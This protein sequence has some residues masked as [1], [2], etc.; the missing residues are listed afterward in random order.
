MTPGEL[1]RILGAP[2]ALLIGIGVAL[3]SGIFRAPGEV[4]ASLPS[5]GWIVIAWIAGGIVAL[6]QGMVTAELATRF[7]KAGGEYVYLREAYGDFVAFFFGWSYTVFIVGA[8]AASI[9]RALGDFSVELFQVGVTWAGPFAALAIIATTIVNAIGLRTG[10]ATQNTL[11]AL[12]V[13]A[14]LVVAGV[15]L[16]YT[17][18]ARDVGPAAAPGL[19]GLPSLS[20]SLTG[21]L[22]VF[23]S[24]AGTTDSVKLAEEI[25]DVRRALPRA[26]IGSAA[27]LTVVYLLFNVA[28]MRVVPAADMA[29]MPSVPGEAMER[30]L[31][32]SGRSAML[33]TAILICLGA[34]TSTVLTTVRVTFAL[35]RDGLAFG[36]LS[37]MS[38]AQSPVPALI[39]VAA[40]AIVLACSREFGRILGI[41]FLASTVLFG[42][43]YASLILFRMRE[44]S[45]PPNIFR[46]PLGIAQALVLIVFQ[47]A[48]AVNIAWTQPKDAQYTL[49]LLAFFAVLYLVWRKRADGAIHELRRGTGDRGA[50]T[51]AGRP[52]R[53]ADRTL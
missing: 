6:M 43:A 33:V 42:L 37:R 31:G 21:F 28:L 40:V 38:K 49:L 3:G 48:L 46:C 39:L 32:A 18:P 17:Q 35:A 45:V 19:T 10:A 29:G 8:G 36:V 50:R 4:A 27:A 23:W 34:L 41:Y 13:L 1:K 20:A 15:G 14:L 11:T 30:A 51:D 53:D 9:A 7:P 44:D 26:V 16:F 24:F 52:P 22:A 5:T 2:T 47:L 12:K 25:Q